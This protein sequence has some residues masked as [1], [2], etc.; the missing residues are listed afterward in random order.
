[1]RSLIRDCSLAQLSADNLDPRLLVALNQTMTAR[2]V[3]ALSAPA[4]RF[5]HFLSRLGASDIL[6]AC[7]TT[8]F[9][10]LEARGDPLLE[11]KT[12]ML[13]GDNRVLRCCRSRCAGKGVDETLELTEKLLNPSALGGSV[14]A[15]LV[16]CPLC[17]LKCK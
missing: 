8:S 3:A 12:V 1:L 14:D 17:F 11:S 5:H 15:S 16:L 2:R 13:H 4:S 9:D 10:G 7:L 6:A